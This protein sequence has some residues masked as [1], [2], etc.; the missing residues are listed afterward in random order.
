MI[1]AAPGVSMAYIGSDS[2]NL[3][4]DTRSV[5]SINFDVRTKYPRLTC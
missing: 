2:H 5:H 1:L 3:E 4:A